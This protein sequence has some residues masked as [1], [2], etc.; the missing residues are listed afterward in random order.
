MPELPEVETARRGIAPHL[1]RPQ[2]LHRRRGARAAPALA[3]AGGAGCNGLRGPAWCGGRAARQVPTDRLPMPA[4]LILHLGMSGSLRASSAP[5]T[6]GECARPC[7]PGARQ[8]PVP[9]AAR[10]APVRRRCCGPRPTRRAHPLLARASARSRSAPA[11]SGE[12]PAPRRHAAGGWRCATLLMDSHVV[13]GRRQ[14]LRQRGAVP[15]RHP[16][17]AGAAGRMTRPDCERLAGDDPRHPGTRASAPAA[18][19]L[20]DFQN[21]DGLPGYFQQTLNVY[22]RSGQPCRRCR[23]PIRGLKLGQRSAFYCPRCQR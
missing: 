7:R 12:L 1:R 6:A 16:P 10:P 20:R 5:H 3:G 4:P 21:A 14:H 11:S 8:R 23:T 2:R 17:A 13:A 9:A 19:T 15:R 18:R 22:G